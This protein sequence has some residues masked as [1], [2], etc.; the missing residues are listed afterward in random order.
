MTEVIRVLIVDD[1]PETRENVRKLLEF[2][3]DMQIAG[4]AGTGEEAI[5]LAKRTQPDIILMDINMPGL[6]GISASQQITELVPHAQIIIMSVQSDPDYMRRAMLAGTR[7]F[8]TKPFG[9]D[10]LVTAVRQVHAKRLAAPPVAGPTAQLRQTDTAVARKAGGHVLTIFSPS[11]GVGCTTVAVNLAIAVAQSGHNTLLIDGSMQFGD[12]AVMLNLPPEASIIELID[13]NKQLDTHMLDS[14]LQIHKPSG[15]HVLLAPPR[16]EMAD[17]LRERHIKPLLEHLKTLYDFIV[18]DTVS[19]LD[20]ITLA[21]LDAAERRVVLTRQYLPSLKNASRFYDITSNLGYEPNSLWLVV[22][23]AS[24]KRG[25]DVTDI[26]GILRRP[27][28]A[29][30]P[31]DEANAW[32]AGD[33]GVPLTLGRA[34]KAPITAAIQQLAEH[35]IAELEPEPAQEDGKSRGALSR[36]F[37]R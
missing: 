34:R 31:L 36:L 35:T 23:F 26:A 8:L 14:A 4:Q 2:E 29:T 33:E 21:F 10:E 25:I 18:I 9:G 5:N 7:Y 37:G 15:L 1:L 12:V 30:V 32:L 22:N 19:K 3:S 11:G 17:V 28:V 16:P 20:E 6:D 27:V 13:N 24:R